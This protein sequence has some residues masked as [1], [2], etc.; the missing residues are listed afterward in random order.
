MYLPRI[1]VIPSDHP[2]K[3]ITAQFP[4]RVTFAARAC[5]SKSQGPSSKITCL[6]LRNPCF[7]H[8][9]LCVG[10]SSVLVT[11]KLYILLKIEKESL[12][13]IEKCVNN[14]IICFMTKYNMYGGERKCI[15]SFDGEA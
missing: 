13:Y 4:S 1:S 3:F 8:V 15:Q 9:R 12:A 6:D 14:F 10:C 7:V 2:F 11:K 5:I